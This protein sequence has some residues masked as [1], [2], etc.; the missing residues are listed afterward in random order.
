MITNVPVKVY[1]VTLKK[2]LPCRAIK[3]LPSGRWRV[4]LKFLGK[5][6]K[7]DKETEH[8]KFQTTDWSPPMS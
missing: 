1:I 2:W 7:I 8:L 5:I 6:K 4:E 3:E